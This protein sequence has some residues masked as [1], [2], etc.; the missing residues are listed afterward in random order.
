MSVVLNGEQSCMSSNN[1]RFIVAGTKSIVC[2]LVYQL[3]TKWKFAI[4][5]PKQRFAT[6]GQKSTI[7]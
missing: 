2:P 5:S 6:I 1:T 7:S 4:R 3:L